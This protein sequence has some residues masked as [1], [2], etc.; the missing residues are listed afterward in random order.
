MGRINEKDKRTNRAENGSAG[1]Q[2]RERERERER[3]RIAFER[4]LK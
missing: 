4:T 1:S 3:E 2:A